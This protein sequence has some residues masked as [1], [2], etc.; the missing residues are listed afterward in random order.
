MLAVAVHASGAV[1]IVVGDGVARKG[2]SNCTHEM[3]VLYESFS[4]GA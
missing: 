3:Q 4:L 2:G 1:L